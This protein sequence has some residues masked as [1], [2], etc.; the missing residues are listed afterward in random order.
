MRRVSA[1]SPIRCVMMSAVRHAA[2]YAELVR[3]HPAFELVAIVEE[4]SA[5][6]MSRATAQELARAC[7]VPLYLCEDTGSGLLAEISESIDL[8]VICSEPTRHARLARAALLKDLHVIVDKPLATEVADAVDIVS[9]AASRGLY[10]TAVNRALLP[11]VQQLKNWV[12][13]GRIG[14]PRSID[15]EFLASGRDFDATVERPELVLDPGLSGGGEVMNFLG[16]MI[17]QVR[18]VSGCEPLQI[19]AEAGTLFNG[20]HARYGVEDTCVLSVLLTNG[21]I[22][23]ITVGRVP[24][25]P[26]PGFATS[27]LRVI[28]SHGFIEIDTESSAL[29]RFESG[30]RTCNL[31]LYGAE[32]NAFTSVLG[33]M[34][35]AIN[36]GVVLPYSCRDAAIAVAATVATYDSLRLQRPTEI[37][38]ESLSEL[39]LA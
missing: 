38:W 14:L 1:S 9:T 24:V 15:A 28:G 39:R 6:Y 10:C 25:V 31:A 20:P 36:S 5:P 29:Q 37:L 19:H 4:L 2:D 11:K 33:T 18:V 23:A 21:V 3:S 27:S 22:A 26:G 8:A 16:Y 32:Q 12:S 7:D 30:R 13:E 34:E 35:A 17:D